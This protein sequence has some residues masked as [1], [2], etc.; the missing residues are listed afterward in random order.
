MAD[1]LRRT[2]PNLTPA[3]LEERRAAA[4][5]R[6]VRISNIAIVSLVAAAGLVYAAGEIF[7]F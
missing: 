1:V 2:D 6:R 7:G 5:R 4:D 3:E